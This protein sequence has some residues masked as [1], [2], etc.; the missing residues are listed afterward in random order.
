MA[1]AVVVQL[2]R[3][4]LREAACCSAACVC[5]K[6]RAATYAR[7]RAGRLRNGS[8]QATRGSAAHCRMASACYLAAGISASRQRLGTKTV[9]P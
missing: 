3:A 9:V 2:A 7:E 1:D 4:R 6:L 8:A 5:L